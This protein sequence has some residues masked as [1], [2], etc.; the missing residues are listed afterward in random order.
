MQHYISLDYFCPWS[1]V[2][3]IL[4]KYYI[5]NV[6]CTLEYIVPTCKTTFLVKPTQYHLCVQDERMHACMFPKL[7]IGLFP[8]TEEFS[9]EDFV[10]IVDLQYKFLSGDFCFVCVKCPTCKHKV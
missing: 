10:S 9:L 2:L 4:S 8:I 5:A 6:T 1:C 7:I 3:F